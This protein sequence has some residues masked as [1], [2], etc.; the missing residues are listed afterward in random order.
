MR[1]TPALVTAGTALALLLGGCAEGQQA[2]PS[3][4]G[5]AQ[6]VAEHAVAKLRVGLTE[7]T[8][9]TSASLVRPGQVRLV[10]TNTGATEHDLEVQG[11]AGRWETP[12]LDPGQ[13][14]TLTVRARPGE[15]LAL[16][17]TE[18]G[19]RTQGMHTVLRATTRP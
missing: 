9:V 7:W 15:T 5:H 1:S 16:W 11:R 4:G 18:P 12:V 17:C 8:I 6:A 13:R 10:V 2:L 19:H 14:T 3:Q